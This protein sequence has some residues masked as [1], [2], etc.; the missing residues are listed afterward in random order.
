MTVTMIVL[1]GL[2]TYAGSLKSTTIKQGQRHATYIQQ[3]QRH[4][5]YIQQS[6]LH[7]I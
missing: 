4:A 1:C 6:Q 3:G 7:A 2:H 5:T